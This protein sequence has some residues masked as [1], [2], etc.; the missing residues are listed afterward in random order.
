M[1]MRKRNL[2]AI[3]AIINNRQFANQE[4]DMLREMERYD[5]SWSNYAYTRY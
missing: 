3:F 4:W 5:W 1:R 2:Q